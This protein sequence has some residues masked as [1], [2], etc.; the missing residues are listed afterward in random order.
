MH[1]ANLMLRSHK[2]QQPAHK[3]IR[4]GY[5][6]PGVFAPLLLPMQIT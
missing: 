1:E 2:Y 5:Q 6:V 4:H 3:I